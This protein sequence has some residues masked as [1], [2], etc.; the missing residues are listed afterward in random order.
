M[1]VIGVVGIWVIAILLLLAESRV[2]KEERRKRK[3]DSIRFTKEDLDKLKIIAPDAN[4]RD[5]WTAP[6]EAES[7][8]QKKFSTE[9]MGRL[10]REYRW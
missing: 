6:V 2:R 10:E 4:I 5:V 1:N 8:L 9:H 3:L 7:P